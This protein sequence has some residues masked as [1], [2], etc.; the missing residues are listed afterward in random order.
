M[1]SRRRR[2]IELER[3]LGTPA[4]FATAYG[5]V[6]SSIYYALG[7]TAI[8]A[9]GL[10]PLVRLHTF[11]MGGV[12]PQIMLTGVI[13]AT[14]KVLQR[15]GLTLADMLAARD[16]LGNG[17][18]GFGDHHL[19]VLVRAPHL[20]ALDEATASCAAALADTTESPG[21][22]VGHY[23]RQ[24]GPIGPEAV[25]NA[26]AVMAALPDDARRAVRY[27]ALLDRMKSGESMLLMPF[28]LRIK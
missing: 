25:A 21:E 10:T 6:G 28:D 17:A 5:N 20:S 27:M 1:P 15:A 3:V 11:A 24:F 7:L 4:L 26:K 13:P 18:V 19:T 8:F 9:L 2:Q 23:L 16:A 14:E 12:D 22:G